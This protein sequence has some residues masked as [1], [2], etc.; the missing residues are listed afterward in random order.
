MGVVVLSQIISVTTSHIAK[1]TSVW[2][3]AIVHDSSM[4]VKVGLLR[5]GLSAD[6]AVE[7]LES[8]MDSTNVIGEVGFLS[9]GPTTSHTGEWFFSCVNAVMNVEVMLT[10]ERFTALKAVEILGWGC[11]LHGRRKE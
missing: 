6:G 9:E 8:I 2:A 3:N 7:W 5:K 11:S 1:H 4:N 10:S